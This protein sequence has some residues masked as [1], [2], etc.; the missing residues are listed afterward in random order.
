MQIA[1]VLSGYSLGEADMLRRAMGKKIKA[2]MDAQRARFVDGA[3]ERGLTKAKADEIFDLLA[4]FAD[5]GFNKSHAAAYAL[6]AYQT[7]WFKANHPVEFLAASM[8]LDKGNTDKLAE[9]RDEA[10]RLGIRVAPPSVN[11]FGGRFRRARWTPTA[12]R[13]S[14]TRF[15]AVKGVGEAQAEALVA[16]RGERGPSRRSPIWRRRL[17]PRGVNKKALESLA[18]GRAPSTSSSPTAAVAFAA[19]EPMLAIANRAA[20]EKAR[21]PERACSAT[22]EPATLRA[23]RRAVAANGTAAGASS[24]PSASSSPAIRSKPM[25]RRSSGCA[26]RAGRISRARCAAARRPRGSRRACST[27]PSGA[28]KPAP[29]WASCSSP[30]RPANMRRSCSRRA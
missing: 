9:F 15:R 22:A 25:T 12:S 17:D 19:I 24:T 5:Y 2:E 18:G 13:R 4:K 14:A 29:R 26:R 20:T 30:I 7:A 8:T 3:V 16:A 23:T 11:R 10:Q 27:A 6:I 21:R 28:P 1:Q